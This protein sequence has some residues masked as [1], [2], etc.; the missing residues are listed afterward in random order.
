MSSFASKQEAEAG[1]GGWSWDDINTDMYP[2]IKTHI[3]VE[4]PHF[5]IGKY[6]LQSGSTFQPAML[7]YG[8]PI[9]APVAPQ[10]VLAGAN[11]AKA[12]QKRSA[13]LSLERSST[14]T[15][16]SMDFDAGIYKSTCNLN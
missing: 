15:A 1:K 4:Y 5:L 14:V 13:R 12:P 9:W 6:H 10:S 2:P 7:V 3:A 8:S 11:A 16:R